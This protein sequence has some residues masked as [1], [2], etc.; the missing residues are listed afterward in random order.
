M[1]PSHLAPVGAL[2]D[3][4]AR[5]ERVRACISVP[6]QHGKT[7]SLIHSIA[8]LLRRDPRRVIAYATYAQAQADSK[9]LQARRIATAAGVIGTDG[10][11]RTTLREWR[12]PQDGGA[13]FTGV[14]GPLTGQTAHVLV[15]DDPFKNRED[16]ESPHARQ[17]VAD[18][19]TSVGLTRLPSHGSVVVVHTRW[20]EDDLIGRIGRGAFGDGWESV[21]LPFLAR[22]DGTPDADG[23]AVLW[24][25]T[26][27]PDGVAVGW[28][29]E[30]ARQRLAEVGPYDAASIYQGQPRPR[31][32]IVFAQPAR[33]T[34]PDLTGARIVIGC[35]PAGT[36]GPNSNHTALVALAVRSVVVEHPETRERYTEQRAD[37]A[38]VLRLKLRPEHAAPQVLAWQRAFGGTPLHIESTRD[39]KELARVLQGVSREIVVQFVPAAG[40][41]FLRAQP[42]AAAWNAGRVR[43][44]MDARSMRQTTDEDLAAFV[45]VVTA[46]AGMG[47]REDDDV[48]ALAHAWGSAT[49]PEPAP[50][51]ARESDFDF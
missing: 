49:T 38:G 28:T 12:T 42:V 40:D 24:P 15:V 2:F 34:A 31:G 50:R 10:D 18:W 16:A 29:T 33:C 30:T 25:R 39:G 1:R 35:D 4:I 43:V 47:D 51:V 21:N 6:A 36:D 20:H 37:L 41:K 11:A 32:G 17:K 13:L 23:D 7:E 46:F 19:F 3:R 45:R 5:G 26:T 8:W 48:D 22:A 9:S 27:R 44:P 14:E